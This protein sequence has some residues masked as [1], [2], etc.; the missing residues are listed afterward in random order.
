MARQF[1]VNYSLRNPETG[2]VRQF[3]VGQKVTPAVEKLLG[4]KL[5]LYTA[6]I[7]KTRSNKAWT[8]AELY[9]IFESYLKQADP[10]NNSDNRKAI[11]DDYN[12]VFAGV[13]EESQVELIVRRLVGADSYYQARGMG[14]LS[15]LQREIANQLAPGRFY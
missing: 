1:T 8:A 2:R 11:V 14:E 3:T 5:D 9:V 15:E 10:H 7:R 12:E 6:V 4:K 13:H